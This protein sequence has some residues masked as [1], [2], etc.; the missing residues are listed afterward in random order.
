MSPIANAYSESSIST[1]K[2]STSFNRSVVANA[3]AS[4]LTNTCSLFPKFKNKALNSEIVSLKTNIQNYVYALEANNK[5]GKTRELKKVEKSYIN[6]QKLRKDL[7]KLEDEKLNSILVRIKRN[8]T[9]LEANYS[10][11][12][13]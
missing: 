12:K 8:I 2:I 4:E 7:P 9:F 11:P 13:K 3:Y 5:M 1:E 6:I 10:N